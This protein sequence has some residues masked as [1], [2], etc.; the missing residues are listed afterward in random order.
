MDGV[1]VAERVGGTAT[2][3][4]CAGV[5]WPPWSACCYAASSSWGVIRYGV[6]H[7]TA[8]RGHSR[9]GRTGE[10]L[11]RRRHR[12]GQDRGDRRPRRGRVGADRRR[13]GARRRA[14][15]HRHAHALGPDAS[16]RSRRREHGPP[17][18]DHAGHRQLQLLAVP[19]GACRAGRRPAGADRGFRV[20]AAVDVEHAGRVGG[21]P[22]VERHE[23]QR[24][25][26]GGQRAPSRRGR[27][28]LEDRPATPTRHA[29]WRTWSPRR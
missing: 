27:C 5:C 13:I 1:T 2:P 25:S 11:G 19:G 24:R 15:L 4:G 6:R 21:S 23:R 3:S 26:A 18:G 29:R 10:I 22:G 14:R 17:G 20:P 28:A 7:G 12:R 16:R 9:W 8:E